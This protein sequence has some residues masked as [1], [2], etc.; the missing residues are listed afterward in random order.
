[1]NNEE[2][3]STKYILLSILGNFNNEAKQ[4]L[5]SKLNP[6][7]SVTYIRGKASSNPERFK[8]VCDFYK[9]FGI[10]DVKYYDLEQSAPNKIEEAIVSTDIVHLGGGNTFEFSKLI[11][12]SN[13]YDCFK[14]LISNN[15]LVVGES[16]GALLLTDNLKI[17]ELLDENPYVVEL[18]PFNILSLSI[19]PHYNTL[20]KEELSSLSDY[21]I[22]VDDT[23]YGINDGGL[24]LIDG[25]MNL[26][27]VNTE[28][29]TNS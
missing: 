20:S 3:K 21:K 7:Y 27:M 9:Q 6:D 23:L 2:D 8:N 12:D 11:T 24:I 22:N 15:M 29:L 18:Q 10:E 19:I 17:A 25:N 16:A 13:H 28:I 1:M 26:H 14:Q 5:E 4:L